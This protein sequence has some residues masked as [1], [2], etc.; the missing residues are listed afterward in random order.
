MQSCT[1]MLQIAFQRCETGIKPNGHVSES[2]ASP[3]ELPDSAPLAVR[4]TRLQKKDLCI[5]VRSLVSQPRCHTSNRSGW[6]RLPG[7]P[8]GADTP[9]PIVQIPVLFGPIRS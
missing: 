5:T 4:R 7:R 8:N 6:C 9:D 1:F 3:T 2:N